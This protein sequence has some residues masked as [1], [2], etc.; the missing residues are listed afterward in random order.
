MVVHIVLLNLMPFLQAAI[1]NKFSIG[2]NGTV[3]TGKTHATSGSSW[4]GSAVYLNVDPTSVFGIP[5]GLNILIIKRP[6]SPLRQQVFL[7][8]RFHLILK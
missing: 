6:L 3:Q 1:T 4:W 8:L 7:M 2:Y 5:C